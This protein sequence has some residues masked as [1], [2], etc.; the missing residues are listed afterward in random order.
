MALIRSPLQQE[1]DELDANGNPVG[2]LGGGAPGEAP[3][4]SAGP[5]QPAAVAPA[6]KPN[7]GGGFVN[8][9]DYLKANE[10]N[11]ARMADKLDDPAQALG[12]GYQQAEAQTPAKPPDAWGNPAPGIQQ[13]PSAFDASIAHYGEQQGRAE[14]AAKEY[15]ELV[16]EGTRKAKL[17]DQNK[18]RG[19]T[20]GESD[21]DNFLT[22]QAAS[23]EWQ[24]QAQQ[25]GTAARGAQT[26]QQGMIDRKAGATESVRAQKEIDDKAAAALKKQQEADRVAA[27]HKANA[28]QAADLTEKARWKTG[29]GFDHRP[30][31]AELKTFLNSNPGYRMAGGDT[32]PESTQDRMTD[33]E[34][35]Q[36]AGLRNHPLAAI[37]IPDFIRSMIEKYGWRKVSSLIDE[38]PE[39]GGAGAVAIGT[40]DYEWL[41]YG[42]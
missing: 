36:L 32:L 37:A 12:Q 9:Q 1:Q 22:G 27:V 35:M 19:Y 8:L 21:L 3:V 20:Q 30:T 33:E 10:G 18:G 13:D 6:T 28:D 17:E 4:G 14:G 40:D 15:G 2:V 23:S 38:Y 39:D 34:V 16:D 7:D 29:T 41:N 26:A 11:G 5:T 31:N 24:N 42:D 25:F